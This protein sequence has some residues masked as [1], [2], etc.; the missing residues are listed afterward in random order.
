MIYP[1]MALDTLNKSG[2]VVAEHAVEKGCAIGLCLD[3][4]PLSY[5]HFM[6]GGDVGKSLGAI[7]IFGDA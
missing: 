4:A 5:L 7:F 1:I 3:V 2:V 6:H